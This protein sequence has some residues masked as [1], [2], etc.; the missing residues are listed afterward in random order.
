VV[1]P[2]PPAKPISETP[3]ADPTRDIAVIVLKSRLPV[4]PAG[5]T[6]DKADPGQH[7]IHAAYAADRRYAL[8]AHF[9]C[10][11]VA[12]SSDGSL[13]FTDCD[14]NP[15]SSGGPLLVKEGDGFSVAASMLGASRR[16]GVTLALPISRLRALIRALG[17][18]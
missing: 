13:W 8:S 16:H 12:G 9:G 15:A 18:P 1:F 6:E 2:L 11:I 7:L 4:R 17:C 3:I 5:I 10:R 14:T